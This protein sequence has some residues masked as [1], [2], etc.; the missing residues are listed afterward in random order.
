VFV[1]M[2]GFVFQSPALLANGPDLQ[3]LAQR[4]VRTSAG[5]KPGEVVLIRGGEHFLPLMEAIGLEAQKSGAHV[6]LLPESE[7]LLR[8]RYAEVA[9]E[10]LEHGRHFFAEWLK[11]VDVYIILPLAPDVE[12][13]IGDVPE[14]RIA[15]IRKANQ[16]FLQMLNEAK[17]RT[18]Y[19]EY[20]SERTAKVYGLDFATYEKMHWAAVHAD[21]QKIADTGTKIK[22]LLEKANTV[23]ITSPSGTDVSLSL[24]GRPVVLIDG[25]V[26]Q[27]EAQAKYAR[28]RRAHLPGGS[29]SFA[30]VET[31]ANGRVIV[32]RDECRSGRLTG[33]RFDFKGGKIENFQAEKGADCYAESMAPYAESRNV[34]GEIWIGLNPQLRVIEEGEADFRPLEGAG[35]VWIQTGRNNMIGGNNKE[36]GGWSFPITR[37]TVQIDGTVVIRDG[38]IVL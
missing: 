26:T 30:P 6:T 15:K 5:V 21:Y 13:I 33:V 9:E 23:W 4:I 12:P 24:K 35:I 11:Q 29:I 8:H 37:A 31:S 14:T 18:I 36:P 34:I 19:V 3:D 22:N 1:L 16:V 38:E 27:E 25:I 17:L 32:P 28:M 7:K 2:S 20:P 10:H